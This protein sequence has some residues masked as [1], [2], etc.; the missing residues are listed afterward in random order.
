MQWCTI[1]QNCIHLL[2]NTI[3]IFVFSCHHRDFILSYTF[4]QFHRSVYILGV[5]K[6]NKYKIIH[7]HVL[8]LLSLT[9]RSTRP[10][11]ILNLSPC[12]INTHG[13][14]PLSLSKT[15]N[16][17]NQLPVHFKSPPVC[18]RPIFI[19]A[20]RYAERGICYGNSVR[21]SVCP[22]V[23]P[24]VTRVDQSKTVEA[25]ITQFS[26]YSSPIPL[27]FDR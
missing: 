7:Q 20:R 27:V 23:H 8:S 26:R 10:Y 22:S 12:E 2:Q 9:E 5:I 19:T 24:S 4:S 6:A 18:N 3:F 13:Q 25:K 15:I 16:T 11:F 17:V 14:S 21:P 1:W